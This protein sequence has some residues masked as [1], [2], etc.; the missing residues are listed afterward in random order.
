[1][2]NKFTNVCFLE[3]IEHDTTITLKKLNW[4]ALFCATFGSG[5]D[6]HRQ[7]DSS[8]LNSVFKIPWFGATTKVPL[9]WQGVPF[10]NP[11]IPNSCTACSWPLFVF[12]FCSILASFLDLSPVQTPKFS[13]PLYL[14]HWIE[15][16]KSSASESIRNVCFNLE[17]LSRSFRL[18]RPGI[19]HLERLRNGFFR[20]RTFHVPN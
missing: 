1:M 13:W 11:I 15:Y 9:S 2:K 6:F 8:K 18:A 4:A 7:N 16:V 3:I 20:G 17:R 5:I 14:I 19:L 12:V 10:F